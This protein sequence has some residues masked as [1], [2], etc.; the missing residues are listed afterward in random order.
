M[1]NI[2]KVAYI[3]GM[4][5]RLIYNNRKNIIDCMG[6]LLVFIIMFVIV[7]MLPTAYSYYN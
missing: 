5:A 3:I 1:I 6:R 4:I 7:G 2:L